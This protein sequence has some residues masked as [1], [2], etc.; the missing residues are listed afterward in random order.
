MR[1]IL[2]IGVGGV[3]SWL[4]WFLHDYYK[5]EQ[6]QEITIHMADGDTVDKKNL[7]YQ[8]FETSD[9]LDNKAEALAERY[10]FPFYAISTN[11]TDTQELKNYDC[12]ICAVDGSTFR[13]MFFNYVFNINPE[14]Y[15]IDLRSESRTVAA[16]TKNKKNTYENMLNTLPEKDVNNGSCQYTFET[17]SGIIQG[18]NVIA[19]A[20]GAQ[21]LLNWYRQDSNTASFIKRF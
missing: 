14:V 2:I 4:S 5:K 7:L 13:K 6:L 3:G 15:W 20:I 18:G 21:L 19:G 8:K 17:N 12:L 16:Y 1:K 9:I 10:Q 11:I